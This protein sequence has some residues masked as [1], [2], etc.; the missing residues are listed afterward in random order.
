M[1]MDAYLKKEQIGTLFA[2]MGALGWWVGGGGS[3]PPN[4][5]IGLTSITFF[6][7]LLEPPKKTKWPYHHHPPNRLI[8]I[9]I[10]S[11]RRQ[12]SKYIIIIGIDTVIG[13]WRLPQQF[14]KMNFGPRFSNFRGGGGDWFLVKCLF[15]WSQFWL[16]SKWRLAAYMHRSLGLEQG[17]SARLWYPLP[18]IMPRITSSPA[19]EGCPQILQLHKLFFFRA[20]WQSPDH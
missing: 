20:E 4:Q 17:H 1:Q 2:W 19:Q 10:D 5:K 18:R 16:K 12:D 6:L 8:Y 13:I 14:G 15:F 7:R 9:P 3:G 11:S